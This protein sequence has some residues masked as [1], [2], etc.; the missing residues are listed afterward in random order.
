MKKN[1]QKPMSIREYISKL[2]E[3]CVFTGRTFRKYIVGFLTGE[4]WY[5]KGFVKAELIRTFIAVGALFLCALYEIY[6]YNIEI[7][8]YNGWNDIYEI[9]IVFNVIIISITSLVVLGYI[10]GTF[11]ITKRYKKLQ[12]CMEKISKGDFKNITINEQIPNFAQNICT[13]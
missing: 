5:K 6:L 7:Y 2:L 8:S 13:L 10:I 4:V 12:C 9:Y 11:I 1:A 3:F